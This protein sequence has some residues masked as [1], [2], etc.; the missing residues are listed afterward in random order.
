MAGFPVPIIVVITGEGGSGGALAL[1]IGDR[2]LM[3]EHAIYS[4]ISPEGCAAILWKDQS[5][6]EDAARALKLTAQDLSRFGIVDE[7]IPEPPGGAHMDPG[8]M[9]DRVSEALRRHLKQLRKSKPDA[10]ITRRYKKF[11]AMGV[12]N[13]R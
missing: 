7:I 5:R 2:V 4:V 10:L 6:A 11:R 9:A 13:D 3:L 12:F 1:G 8:T